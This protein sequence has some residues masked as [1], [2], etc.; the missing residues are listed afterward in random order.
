MTDEI[1]EELKR[2]VTETGVV[3]P[4]YNAD[5][6]LAGSRRIDADGLHARRHTGRVDGQSG[7]IGSRLKSIGTK[8]SY[9]LAG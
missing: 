3:I 4:S 1:T 7:A 6:H 2:I 8:R 5:S 9:R